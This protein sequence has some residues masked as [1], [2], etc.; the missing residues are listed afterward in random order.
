MLQ[1]PEFADRA[2]ADRQLR[3]GRLL[4]APIFLTRTR[5]QWCERLLDFEVPHSAVLASNEVLE[6]EQI[7]TCE[8][9]VKA[10]HPVMG[11]FRT[12]RNPVTFDGE[13]SLDVLPPPVL[14]E[15]DDEILP[16]AR[17]ERGLP[18]RAR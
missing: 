18:N 4:L 8:M 6:T 15:H 13:R 12:I 9:E 7:R 14:G 3:G 17:R 5:D 11:P 16:N 1:Q 10:E 2:C